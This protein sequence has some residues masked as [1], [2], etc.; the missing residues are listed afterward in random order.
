MN[1]FE[2]K[3]SHTRFEDFKK[4][5]L[6]AK[7]K[8]DMCWHMDYCN[9]RNIPW[10]HLMCGAMDKASIRAEYQVFLLDLFK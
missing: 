8:F 4:S 10:V 5:A 7:T 6:S 2:C 3:F 9:W 1:K